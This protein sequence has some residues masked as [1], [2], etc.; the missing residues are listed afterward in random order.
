MQH[1]FLRHALESSCAKILN[2]ING[3]NQSNIWCQ[4]EP[5]K[6]RLLTTDWFPVGEGTKPLTV[7]NSVMYIFE[8]FQKRGK[9]VTTS[10][11]LNKKWCVKSLYID[12]RGWENYL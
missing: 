11:T 3:S 2:N 12:P 4:S 1:S 8:K 7:S 10:N 6:R 9:C 5:P